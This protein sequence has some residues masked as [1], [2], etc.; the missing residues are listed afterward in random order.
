MND[1]VL[2]ENILDACFVPML[3]FSKYSELKVGKAAQKFI[4]SPQTC[5][6]RFAFA[7]DY[8]EYVISMIALYVYS[9]FA[10]EITK[11]IAKFM[12]MPETEFASSSLIYFKHI[13]QKLQSNGVHMGCVNLSALQAYDDRYQELV[14]NNQEQYHRAMLKVRDEYKSFNDDSV[15]SRQLAEDLL[16]L[17]IFGEVREEE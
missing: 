14:A 1:I 8:F 5:A 7:D 15:R 4:Q 17:K 3:N 16:F 2:T 6:N 9:V 10:A 12:P 11:N 13:F